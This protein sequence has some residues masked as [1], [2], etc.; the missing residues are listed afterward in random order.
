MLMVCLCGVALLTGEAREFEV[1]LLKG[2]GKNGIWGTKEFSMHVSALGVIRYLQVNGK[3]LIWQAA[4]LYTRP[5]A[6]GAEQGLRTVQGEGFGKR[7]LTMAA[8]LRK[9]ESQHGKRIFEFTHQ[10]AKPQILEGRTLCEVKQRIVITP[11]GEI[12][13]TYDCHWLE[14]IRWHGFDILII[15]NKESVNRRRCIVYAKDSVHDH[16]LELDQGSAIKNRIRDELKQLCIW[17]AEGPIHLLWQERASSR[18]SWYKGAETYFRPP[19]VPYRGIV[20]KGQRSRIAYRILLPVS[21]Q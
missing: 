4:A 7:G 1:R 14:T 16:V 10:I 2:D 6:P 19:A 3:E 18:F 21:Q 8:P 17:S 11:T 13:V 20:Y 5:V 9:T 15:F 12:D